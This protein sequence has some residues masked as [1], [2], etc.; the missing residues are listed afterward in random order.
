MLIA[1]PLIMYIRWKQVPLEELYG[2]EY[3]RKYAWALKDFEGELWV[4]A[5]FWCWNFSPAGW[6]MTSS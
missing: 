2:P 1:W 3:R 4:W 6:S 5:L